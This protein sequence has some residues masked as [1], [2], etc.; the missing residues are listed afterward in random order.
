VDPNI[1]VGNDVA[2]RRAR[3]ETDSCILTMRQG[4]GMAKKRDKTSRIKT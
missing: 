3:Q 1:K 4:E 2:G